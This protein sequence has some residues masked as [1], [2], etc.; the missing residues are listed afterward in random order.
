V[1]F[2]FSDGLVKLSHWKKE[3][4]KKTWEAT[5]PINRRDEQV[6]KS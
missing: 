5:H 3:K 2:V 6:G 4:K 1:F